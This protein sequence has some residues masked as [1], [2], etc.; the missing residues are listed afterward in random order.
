MTDAGIAFSNS[1]LSGRRAASRLSSTWIS[2]RWQRKATALKASRAWLPSRLS[3]H[4]ISSA[5][6][7]PSVLLTGLILEDLPYWQREF[8]LGCED[9]DL[10]SDRRRINYGTGMLGMALGDVNGDGLEDLYVS[11]ISGFPNRL[12]IH[13]PD[14]SVVDGAEEAGVDILD[15]TRGCLMV[16]LDNDGDQEPLRGSPDRPPPVLE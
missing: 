10:L 7:P 13:Q 16:D 3:T 1:G 14:G 15:T 11:T 5:P 8:A 12:F 4:D 6:A 9:Y 2:A